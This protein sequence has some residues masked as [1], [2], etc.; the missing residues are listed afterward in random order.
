MFAVF[1]RIHSHFLP[2]Y[3]IEVVVGGEAQ[4]SAQLGSSEIRTAQ[5]GARLFDPD[6]GEEVVGNRHCQWLA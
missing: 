3:H 2:E 1:H 4:H 5:D 6:A